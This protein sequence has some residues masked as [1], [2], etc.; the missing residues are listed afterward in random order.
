M[1]VKYITKIKIA[2]QNQ[3]A[4]IKKFGTL[5]GIVNSYFGQQNKGFSFK[6]QREE[7]MGTGINSGVANCASFETPSFKPTISVRAYV[8]HI[9]F[10]QRLGRQSKEEHVQAIIKMS[11]V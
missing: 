2:F 9:S 3:Q 4:S 11:R 8:L 5:C 1:F 10:S 7:S 6:R